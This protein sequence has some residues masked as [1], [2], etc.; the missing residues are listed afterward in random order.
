MIFATVGSRNYQ[1]NRLFSKLD[2]LFDDGLITEPLFAQIGTS[3]YKPKNYD[4]CNYFSQDDFLQKIRESNIVISHGGS[5]SIV[6]A[7]NEGKKVIIV[8]R[9]KKYGEHIN[10][11]QILEANNFTSKCYALCA[12]LELNNLGDCIKLINEGRDGILPWLKSDPQIIVS[13]IDKFIQ[14]NWYI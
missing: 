14:D 13:L 3:S 9:L 6:K 7:L 2:D 12:D 5:G 11:H 8:V 1:F 4:Y 10:D